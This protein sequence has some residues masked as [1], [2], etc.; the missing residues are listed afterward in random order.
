MGSKEAC[1]A[2]DEP[3]LSRHKPPSKT[4]A[5]RDRLLDNRHPREKCMPDDMPP[6]AQGKQSAHFATR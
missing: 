4:N 2:C 1:A 3:F 6:P 5:Q